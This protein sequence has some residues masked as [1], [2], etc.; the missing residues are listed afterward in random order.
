MKVFIWLALI[1]FCG[2]AAIHSAA[3]DTGA[4]SNELEVEPME[5]NE[6]EIEEPTSTEINAEVSQETDCSLKN[7]I[8]SFFKDKFQLSGTG[9]ANVA[10]SHDDGSTEVKAEIGKRWQ[11]D[12]GK[13]Q[14]QANINFNGKF[15]GGDLAAHP[16]NPNYSASLQIQTEW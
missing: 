13:T 15:N 9:K 4:Y 16:S 6:V 12:D 5:M 1:L 3:I 11:S 10:I 7:R 2:V 14:I 8:V